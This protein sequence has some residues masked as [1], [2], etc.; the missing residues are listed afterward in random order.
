MTIPEHVYLVKDNANSCM[1]HIAWDWHDKG[2]EIRNVYAFKKPDYALFPSKKSLVKRWIKAFFR[3][4]PACIRMR[5]S[6]IYCWDLHLPMMALA[7]ILGP[8]MGSYRL[9]LDNFYLH[10][11]SRR[12]VVQ[13]VLRFLMNNRHLTVLTY[14]QG[15]VE[16]Y[17]SLS[18][19]AKVHFVPFCSDFYPITDHV[20]YD[21]PADGSYIFTGGYT[22]RDYDIVFEMARRFPDRPFVV[23]ASSL[24]E[25]PD[26]ASLPNMK[27]YRDLPKEQFESL[28]ANSMIVLVPLKEDVGASGQMLSISTL[29][30]GRP[31]IYTD[32]SVVNYFF[33]GGAGLPYRLGDAD[34]MA[35]ALKT[36]L[37]SAEIRDSLGRRARE[38]AADFTKA[39][40]VSIINQAL[41]GQVE[42][43]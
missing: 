21:A 16:F 7:R 41:F 42:N 31:C 8:V 11:M 35:S 15:E 24:N 14:S 23:V 18:S 25:L 9:V 39:R 20:P 6:L 34:S 10:G 27:V 13:R 22:N 33:G 4:I 36:C 2:C 1:L 29:R 30:N 32:L 5:G 3:L 37:D 17:R 12:R 38:A 43:A 26:T 28:L 40:Q 19:R